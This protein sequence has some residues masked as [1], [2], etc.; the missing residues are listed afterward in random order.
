MNSTQPIIEPY[1]EKQFTLGFIPSIIQSFCL[2]LFA[3]LGDKTFIMLIILQMKTNRITVLCSSLLVQVGMNLLAATIGFSIDY[4]LYKNLIDYVGILFFSVYG[5]W[6]VG[7]G[8]H[9][10]EQSFESELALDKKETVKNTD[11][12]LTVPVL[13]KTLTIIPEIA[14]DDSKFPE[15]NTLNT[16]LLEHNNSSLRNTIDNK[17]NDTMILVNSNKNVKMNYISNEKKN[18]KEDV[19]DSKMFFVIAQSMALSECGD[20]TQFTSM[21]M[22][23]IFNFYGVIIGSCSALFI[24]VI[25][26]VYCGKILIKFLH[27]KVLTLALGVLLLGYSAQIYLNK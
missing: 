1:I 2:T 18:S 11:N 24:T 9:S 22:A 7:E 26:G 12:N 3:E 10:S 20:R 16:P 15:E 8:F 23:A 17:D 19:L 13:P 6:L 27:E 25:L 5:F 21:A 14:R 4:M